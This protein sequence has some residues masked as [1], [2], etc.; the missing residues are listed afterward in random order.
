MNLCPQ[1]GCG[2]IKQLCSFC[3]AAKVWRLFANKTVLQFA[4]TK[5]ENAIYG[6]LCSLCMTI[7]CS[8]DLFA[9]LE[10]YCVSGL[11]RAT[12]PRKHLLEFSDP[13]VTSYMLI[14]C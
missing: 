7:K 13:D 9:I 14:Y 6:N 12:A 1:I 5:V 10:I 4:T 11:K 2:K 8:F 3:F